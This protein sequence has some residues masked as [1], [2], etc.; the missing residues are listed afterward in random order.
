MVRLVLKSVLAA[1]SHKWSFS[2]PES[3]FATNPEYGATHTLL[4]E[5][6]SGCQLPLILGIYFISR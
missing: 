2:L 5:S 4:T 3:N 1:L 6:Q